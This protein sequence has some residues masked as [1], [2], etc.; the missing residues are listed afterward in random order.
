MY[1]PNYTDYFLRAQL[2]DFEHRVYPKNIADPVDLDTI[3]HNF[4]DY[5]IEFYMNEYLFNSFFAAAADLG[6]L[7]ITLTNKS[8][9]DATHILH[10]TAD[11]FSDFFPELKEKYGTDPLKL[12]CT[13]EKQYPRVYILENSTL[14]G[15][16]VLFDS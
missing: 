12:Q 14:Y 13:Y 16:Y 5:N 7:S 8:V 1:S 3:S 9:F 6:Y 2:C 11:T 4:G 15:M 10:L